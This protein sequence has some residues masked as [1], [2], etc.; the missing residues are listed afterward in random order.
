MIEQVEDI[1]KQE[2]SKTIHELE[3]MVQE[4]ENNKKKTCKKYNVENKK[5]KNNTIQIEKN[6]MKNIDSQER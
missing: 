6:S 2:N 1:K 4:T 3:E 5:R